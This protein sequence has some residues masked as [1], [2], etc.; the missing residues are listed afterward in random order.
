MGHE[1]CSGS[2]W[3]FSTAE[4]R[5]S[6]VLKAEPH[7]VWFSSLTGGSRHCKWLCELPSTVSNTLGWLFPTLDVDPYF[8]QYGGRPSVV[9]YEALSFLVWTHRALWT[10]TALV[11]LD[12][13]LCLINSESPPGSHRFLSLWPSNSRQWAGPL[14]GLTLFVSHLLEVVVLCWLIFRV[15]SCILSECLVVSGDRVWFLWL[16]HAQR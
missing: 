9:L 14:V 1:Q 3:S 10:L 16:L 5:P 12:F 13:H 15:F 2:N 11:S 4:A 6:C 7:D 8:I